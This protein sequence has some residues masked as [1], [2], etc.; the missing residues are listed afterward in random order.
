MNADFI[1]LAQEN[2][3]ST[4]EAAGTAVTQQTAAGA[5]QSA[6]TA[7][8]TEQQVP[9]GETQAP[10]GGFLGGL[11]GM[12]PM[13]I[14]LVVMFYLMFRSQKKERQRHQDMLT[15]LKKGDKIVTAGG[16][17]GEIAEIRDDSFVVQVAPG[18]N[19]TFSRNAIS[20]VANAGE[21]N[22]GK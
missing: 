21:G 14:I 18:I 13:I 9:E 1:I 12:L 19:M 8:T 10:Q 11:G 15:S 6:E 17:H 7:V 16:I 2:A 5:Q 20:G 3:V 22:A 4:A